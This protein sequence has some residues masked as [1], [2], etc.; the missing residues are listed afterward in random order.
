MNYENKLLKEIKETGVKV[1]KL[2]FLKNN[3]FE[4]Q[5][6]KQLL[7]KLRQRLNSYY[8]M[9]IKEMEDYLQA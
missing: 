5:K 4:L 6:N 9:K 7:Q 1:R 3:E 2:E 8:E